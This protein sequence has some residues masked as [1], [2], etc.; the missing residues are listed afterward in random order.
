[1]DE[2][3]AAFGDPDFLQGLLN[4]VIPPDGRM[5]GAGDLDLWPAVNGWL[6]Q[7]AAAA[8]A[9]LGAGLE[10]VRNA[11]LARDPGGLA[12]LPAAEALEVVEAVTAGD[13]GLMPS[14]ARAI[15]MVYY[16]QPAVLVALGEPARP[17][18]P[19]GFELD[20]ISPESLSLLEGR[21]QP[22][23]TAGLPS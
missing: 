15:A 12:A 8:L 14:L 4:L 23:N 5:P 11:A 20:P 6:R 19:D 10:A 13:P 18:F 22:R 1:M 2:Q 7:N 21:A 3:P 9:S 17:P 16:Q